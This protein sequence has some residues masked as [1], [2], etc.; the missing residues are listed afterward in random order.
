[1]EKILMIHE[2][3]DWMLDLD[4]SEY[5]IFTFDDGLLSQYKHYTHFLSYGKP[6]YFFISTD[7]VCPKSQ[8]Q[9]TKTV[10]CFEALRRYENGDRS[11]YMTWEQIKEIQ[12][13]PNCYIGGHGHKHLRLKKDSIK[14]TYWKVKK[15]C[16]EMYD[17]FKKHD[18]TI[19]S[20]CF[21]HNEDVFGYRPT[22]KEYGIEYFFGRERIPI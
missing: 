15:D 14:K 21:P 3:E 4:L 17:A 13:T 2:V 8:K 1:M 10:S 5:D 19:N 12:K 7:M 18:I 9:E 20:F 16:M 11:C 6:M 22:L